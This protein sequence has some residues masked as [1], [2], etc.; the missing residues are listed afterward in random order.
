LAEVRNSINEIA[1]LLSQSKK[2]EVNPVIE[3]D[4]VAPANKA[5]LKDTPFIRL[6]QP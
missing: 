1:D 4:A 3:I 5:Q 2:I 6:D